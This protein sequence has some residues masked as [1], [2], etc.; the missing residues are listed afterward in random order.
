MTWHIEGWSHEIVFEWVDAGGSTPREA[1][2]SSS[3]YRYIG[4]AGRPGLIL[5][6]INP[7]R[8]G[9]G[10]GRIPLPVKSTWASANFVSENPQPVTF[11]DEIGR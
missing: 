9:V 1:T 10:A 8:R 6:V 11:T 5:D 4:R 3:V 2:A 7:H